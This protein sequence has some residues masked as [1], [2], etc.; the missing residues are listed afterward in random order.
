M[1][2]RKLSIRTSANLNYRLIGLDTTCAAD[3]GPRRHLIAVLESY[4]ADLERGVAQ[5][6]Q[7]LLN[8]HPELADDLLPYLES[9]RLLHGATHDMRGPRSDANGERNEAAGGKARQI[10]E[11]R[12]VREIGRGGMGIVYEAHQQSLN[13]QVALKILPF[14]AVLDQR[15][16]ARF[17]NEAQAAAQLHHPHIV[18][19][20]AVGQEQGVYYYAMQFIDGQSLEQTIAEL[21]EARERGA[22]NSTSAR[23]AVNGSTT[24]LHTTAGTH[25]PS[26]RTLPNGDYFRTIARLGKEAAEAL[27]HAHEHGILH[28]DIKPSNLL[29]DGQGKLWVTDFGLARIQNDNGVTLTGDLVGTLRYMSPE[30]ASGSTLVDARTDVYSLGATLYEL[31]TLA[32]SHRGEDRPTLLRQI[33]NDEPVPPRKINPAVPIDLETIVLGAMA[34]TQNDRYVSAQALA[35]DLDRFLTGKPTLARRPTVVDRMGKWARR[36]RALVTVAAC[37]IAL[38]SVVSVVGLVLLAREQAQTSAALADAKRHFH[39][40]RNAV[41]HFGVGLSDKLAEYPGAEGVRRDLLLDTLA[42]YRQFAKDAGDDPQL[43]Q[44]TAVAHFKSGAIAAKLGAVSDAILEYETAQKLFQQLADDDAT[45]TEPLAQL[46]LTHNNLGLLF[47][48]RS[49]TARARWEYGD[50]IAIQERLVRQ[51]GGD[52][53]FAG[54]LA[55]SQANLG[56]LLDQLGDSK[57]AEHA[58]L[59]AVDVLRPLA[60]SKADGPRASRELAIALNNLSFVVRNRDSSEAEKASREAIGILERLAGESNATNNYQG[61]LALCYNNLAAL[62]SQK[63]RWPAAIDWHQRA[64]RLQEQMARKS[65]GVV[66]HRSDLAISMNN[67]GMAYCRAAKPAEG[68]EAFDEARRMFASLA[69]DY[70][71]EVAYRSSLAALLNNQAL[72]LAEVGRHRD[73]L[74]I[75]SAAID[76]QRKCRER[77]PD[78]EMMRDLL[79][80]MYY[81]FG[82]SLRAERRL[83]EAADA[84]LARREL[85]QGN[86]ERLLGVAAEL[87]ELDSAMDAPSAGDAPIG[88]R[89][90][91]GEDVLATLD[92]S[93]RDG[94][95]RGIDVGAD[96][97]FA[98]LMNNDRFAAKVAELSA[99]WKGAAAKDA[100][101]TTSRTGAN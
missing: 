81:N 32:H 37:A 97:R 71:D 14:A 12:I 5:D 89:R 59:A 10:G 100:K 18:P 17:R 80:K 6:Q 74:D 101:G 52:G 16:I 48:D 67:L 29:I 83:G 79:S 61:D 78:S 40:A 68:D 3:D 44:E 11:Y 58:L 85:W 31:V 93:F 39:Q 51:R 24:T 47:A 27:Q 33:V 84:A 9:L 55:E 88:A 41:D 7:S 66:R 26:R 94:W 2:Q 60:E 30:Q 35:D 87:A 20:F 99:R 90:E 57:G 70:P 45:R 91:L 82:R 34:K 23:G 56:L 15:H 64:I 22:A 53:E 65:P 28:R 8:A 1:A 43:R 75:Y 95:P 54:D 92:Q 62:E 42:Y 13:R 63:G 98:S 50:A 19:V 4:M 21:R 77:V 73:A 38:V 86:G 76:A 49:D 25:S 69:D 72:A 36:H 46:A 96:E